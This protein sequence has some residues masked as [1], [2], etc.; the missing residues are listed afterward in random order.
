MEANPLPTELPNFDLETAANM[1]MLGMIRVEPDGFVVENH[2]SSG[3]V[4]YLAMQAGV[5]QSTGRHS[6]TRLFNNIAI[7]LQHR[8]WQQ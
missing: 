8:P 4:E 7:R 3:L 6:L 2:S 5:V 1:Q